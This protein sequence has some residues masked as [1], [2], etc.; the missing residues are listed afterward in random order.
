MMQ[1][2]LKTIALFSYGIVIGSVI[3]WGAVRASSAENVA[4]RV[5]VAHDQMAQELNGK[6]LPEIQ[7]QLAQLQ[8]AAGMTRQPAPAAAPKK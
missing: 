1:E 2:T 4:Q 5:A 7:R 8:G 3:T 6:V